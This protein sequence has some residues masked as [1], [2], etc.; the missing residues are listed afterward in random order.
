MACVAGAA[1]CSI[2]LLRRS[3]PR[4]NSGVI[5]LVHRVFLLLPRTRRPSRRRRRCSSS[6]GQGTAPP[7]LEPA[8]TAPRRDP[9][10]RRPPHPASRPDRGVSRAP[11]PATQPRRRSVTRESNPPSAILPPRASSAPLPPARSP[12]QRNSRVAPV[13]SDPGRAPSTVAS[14]TAPA[15]GTR[16]AYVSRECAP[17]SNLS[18]R[19]ARCR[20]AEASPE[21]GDSLEEPRPTRGE[22][23]REARRAPRSSGI[24]LARLRAGAGICSFLAGV[25]RAGRRLETTEARN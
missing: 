3:V 13:R 2:V 18:S 8:P 6:S 25:Q 7:R 16:C 5:V 12:A 4:P 20:S 14:A 19:P 24:S 15:R 22:S 10:P 17:D 23:S 1:A 21:Q 9:R 11:R